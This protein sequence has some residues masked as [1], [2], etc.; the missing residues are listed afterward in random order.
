MVRIHAGWRVSRRQ[1]SHRKTNHPGMSYRLKM[2]ETIPAGIRRI[3]RQQLGGALGE[4]GGITSGEEATA[5]HE[6]RKHIKKIRAVLRLVRNEIGDGIYREEDDRLRAIARALSAA[7]DARVQLQVLEKLSVCPG[8]E[9]T[10]FPKTATALHQ[11]IAT[12]SETFGMQRGAA[13]TTLQ[14][15][16]DRLEGWPLEKLGIDDLCAALRR[17][18]RRGRKGFLGV[19]SD[20]IPENF[21][22]WRKRVKDLW[23]QT[24]ILQ[25][26]NPEVMREI[27]E[28]ARTLG[29]QLGD[30]HDLA[31]YHSRL[32]QDEIGGSEEHE[33]L[34]GLACTGERELARTAIDLG[35]RFFAEKPGTFGR[36]LLRYA[37]KWP[38]RR[39][40]AP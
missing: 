8:Q 34:L 20:P 6:T 12:A 22:T 3:A 21:H 28:A 33:V 9:S 4:I 11:E 15:I 27:A 38:A 24:L 25:D 31:L 7:R 13:E 18:Y 40:A 36:R 16:G 1:L 5:V 14:G 23:Y 26:L 32:E 19:N 29:R 30:L 10:P 17:S 2:N 37:R 39:D 35:A